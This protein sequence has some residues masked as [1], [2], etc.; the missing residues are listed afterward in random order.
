M[1]CGRV[2]N[3]LSAY[4]DRE[5]G[6]TEMLQV[7]EHL[8]A[9]EVCRREHAE[10]A[11]MKSLLGR[12]PAAAPKGDF[13]GATLRRMSAAPGAAPA[14]RPWFAI[15]RPFLPLL[16]LGQSARVAALATCLVVALIATGAAL[17]QPVTADAV[18]AGLS[19]AGA[20]EWQVRPWEGVVSRGSAWRAFWSHA[21]RPTTATEEQWLLLSLAEPAGGPSDDSAVRLVREIAHRQPIGLS[22]SLD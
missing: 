2:T 1:L 22:W 4:I 9:C 19:R 13:V 11:E 17:R 15:R 6:G 5:L 3:L 10:F 8:S 12:M 20:E 7:R 14:A 21:P 16:V 18:V